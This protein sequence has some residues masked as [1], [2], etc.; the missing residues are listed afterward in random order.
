[1][2]ALTC[3][4]QTLSLASGAI[5]QFTAHEKLALLVLYLYRQLNTGTVG[6]VVPAATLL[7]SASCLSCDGDQAGTNDSLL[8]SFEVW[9]Q[10]NAAID[11]GAALSTFNANN[12]RKEITP[13]AN[14]SDHQLRAIEICLRAQLS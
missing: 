4:A 10:R 5:N 6:Q 7:K 2:A 1:M 13:L 14:L 9:I 11:A 3:N 12:A 8:A